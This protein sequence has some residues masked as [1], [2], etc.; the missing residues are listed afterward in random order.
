MP[1]KELASYLFLGEEDFLKET[2]LKKLKSRFLENATKDLNYNV[3][4]AKDKDFKLKEMLDILNTAPFMSPKRFVILKDADSL[5]DSDK[6][7][8][9]FYL[10]NPK[11]TSIFII[12]SKAVKIKEGFILEASKLAKFVRS[13]KLTDSEISIWISRRVHS[14]GK[15]IGADAIK[16]IKENL[17]NDLH[18]LSSSIDNLIL[19]AGKRPD[20]TRQDVEKFIYVAPLKSSF[21]L[22]DAIEKKDVKLALNIFTSIQKYKKRETEFLLG[23]LS[24]QFRML[25]R[26]K[27]LLKIRSKLEIQKELNL[28]NTK[29]D[30][31]SRYATR[32]KRQE[33]IRLL[34]EIL[35]AD[36]DIK[37]GEVSARFTLE[38]LILK[39]CS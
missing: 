9:L 13:S 26:V 8:V 28:Y 32:F 19:Y 2:E 17:S 23:L 3:F 24:W 5:S 10:K 14:S 33:I 15:K 7:S 4:Y 16:L 27:E 22:L 34:S 12:D 30:Q 39:I 21:D 31:M 29:F 36:S 6:E 25:L 11:D 37:T 18:V 20:I 38:K 35:K 1:T